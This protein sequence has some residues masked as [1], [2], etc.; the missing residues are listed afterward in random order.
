MESCLFGTH[1][2]SSY[3]NIN[4][5]TGISAIS[6]VLV[7]HHSSA[8]YKDTIWNYLHIFY[9]AMLDHVITPDW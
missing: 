9:S 4:T 3:I 2:T 1:T 7:H 5:T 8:E 6:I